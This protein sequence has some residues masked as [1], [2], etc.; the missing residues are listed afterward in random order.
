[1]MCHRPLGRRLRVRAVM[2]AS[3]AGVVFGMVT[4][5]SAQCTSQNCGPVSSGGT[6]STFERWIKTT[7]Q[8]CE[9]TGGGYLPKGSSIRIDLHAL[10][11]GTCTLRM[12]G[13]WPLV[14]QLIGTQTRTV[15]KAETDETNPNGLFSPRPVFNNPSYP[16]RPEIDTR[17]SGTTAP[18]NVIRGP[19]TVEGTWLYE[20]FAPT[21]W[22]ACDFMPHTMTAPAVKIHVLACTPEWKTQMD[23]DLVRNLGG[24]SAITVVVPPT[25]PPNLRQGIENAV[26]GWEAAFSG[27]GKPDYNVVQ[28]STPCTPGPFCINV[29]I[30][31]LRI[32]EGQC[33][34]SELGTESAGIIVTSTMYFPSSSSSWLLPWAQ[35]WAAHELA[36]HLGLGE[37]GDGCGTSDSLMRPASCTATGLLQEPTISDFVPVNETVY[38]SGPKT[39]CEG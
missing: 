30:D 6:V 33:A 24:S 38:G 15:S 36:H 37:K 35:H 7:G 32:P 17:P 10:V 11:D 29:A 23:G 12:C 2:L 16:P 20:F 28:S 31:D 26:A 13:G 34:I 14:C 8:A 39:V 27:S 5:V 3:I 25:Y 9:M 21:S 1:M 19:F 4:P 22:T 18:D